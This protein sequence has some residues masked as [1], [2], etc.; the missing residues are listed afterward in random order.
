MSF[1]SYYREHISI[2][3]RLRDIPWGF[4][5]LVCVLAMIGF[6]ALYSA[7]GGKFEPWAARQ[8]VRFGFGII[9][10]LAVAMVDLRIWLKYAYVIYGVAL[11]L[12]LAVEAMGLISAGAQRW[13]NLGVLRLQPSEVMKVALVLAL[14][15]YFHKAPLEDVGRFWRL[16]PPFIMIGLPMA[17]VLRQPDLGTAALLGFVGAFMLF[18]AGVQTWKFAAVGALGLA[19][20]PFAWGFLHDYQKKRVLTFLDPESDPLGAG[21]HII[22]SKIAL[23]SGGIWG[24]GYLQGSQSHLS[25]I[26]ETQ[27]DF[28]FSMFS[29]EFG[30]IGGV[31]LLVLF[32]AVII[33]GMIIAMRSRNQFGRMVAF[34]VSTT[35][36]LYVFMNIA[37]VTGL[38]PVVGV[39]LPL[40]SYGGTAM[41]TLMFGFGLILSVYINRDARISRFDDED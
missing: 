2:V 3:A 14:A 8:M 27:T 40:I 28:V 35:L 23:G 1:P 17:L 11:I 4:V 29:E 38:I 26:P 9:V 6:A 19:A 5:A 12:L 32:G 18:A 25:F 10:L 30:L 13:I 15:R 21:Y 37:M 24:K 20:V 16:I 7:A 34:G 33:Y 31:G 41:L 22:Q 39:P 36:F